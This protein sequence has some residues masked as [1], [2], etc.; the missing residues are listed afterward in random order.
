MIKSKSDYYRFL[1]A[2]KEALNIHRVYPRP[3]VDDIWR[4]QRLLRKLEY[5]TNCK[6]SF[7]YKPYVLILKFKF[8]KLSRILGF[9]IP[10]NVFGPGLSIAHRGT[11]VVNGKARI[12][13]NCRIHACVNIGTGNDRDQKVP[14]IGNNIYIGPGA[15]I[16]GEIVIGDNTAIGANAV[17]N[18]SFPE[19]NMTIAGIPARKI[20]NKGTEELLFRRKL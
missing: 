5:Y 12:G 9:D 6:K 18:K 7:F 20:S 19:G 13:A 14:T 1:Q 11:I 10:I 4:F 17:V 2:D 3:L 15:K 16:F 8:H